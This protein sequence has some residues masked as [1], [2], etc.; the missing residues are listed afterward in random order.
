MKKK[1]VWYASKKWEIIKTFSPTK[2]DTY[3][4]ISRKDDE[5]IHIDNKTTPILMCLVDIHND[6]FYPDI[7]K[8]RSFM[9]KIKNQ[10]NDLE[11]LEN[12]LKDI[13]LHQVENYK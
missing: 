4:L 13:W 12:K 8:V 11:L 7:P 5:S 1:Y 3:I 10:N 6:E 9:S 2:F